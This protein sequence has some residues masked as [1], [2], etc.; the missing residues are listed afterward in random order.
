M[1]R[2][3]VTAYSTPCSRPLPTLAGPKRGAR[4]SAGRC[5]AL[6]FRPPTSSRLLFADARDLLDEL[7]VDVR[8]G[9]DQAASSVGVAQDHLNGLFV[10]RDF[11]L[12]EIAHENRLPRHR[13]LS[14]ARF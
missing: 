9:D 3:T 10:V 11:F 1:A 14:F 2:C 6:L 8:I 7:V 4:R 12:R 13:V 5:A